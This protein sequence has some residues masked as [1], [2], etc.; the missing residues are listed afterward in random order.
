MSNVYPREYRF[1][2]NYMLM[3]SSFMTW[4]SII[5]DM[6]QELRMELLLLAA[7]TGFAAMMNRV[8]MRRRFP[9]QARSRGQVWQYN[10]TRV[11]ASSEVANVLHDQ[12]LGGST[13][14]EEPGTKLTECAQS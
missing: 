12:V 9:Q 8:R 6:L 2:F 4:P 13:A 7:M 5:V 3:E 11:A 14:R 1:K 10:G